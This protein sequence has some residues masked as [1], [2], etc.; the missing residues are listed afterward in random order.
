MLN[1]S[2]VCS[3]YLVS[4][5]VGLRTYQHSLVCFSHRT[6]LHSP[7][8]PLKVWKPIK[9]V[10]F[11][12]KQ[13]VCMWGTGVV[14]CVQWQDYWLDG[15]GSIV[16]FPAK[17]RNFSPLQKVETGCGTHPTFYSKGKGLLHWGQSGR[18]VKLT[19]PHHLLPRL[20]MNGAVPLLPHTTSWCV[21]GQFHPI[22]TRVW[23]VVLFVLNIPGK[24]SEIG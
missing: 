4:F 13:Q 24:E 16:P 21:N 3:L 5:L 18:S 9:Q 11:S 12:A 2:R 23:D 15:R 17:S 8:I 1:K 20:R 10:P 22:N 19:T 7:T 6:H 14:Q